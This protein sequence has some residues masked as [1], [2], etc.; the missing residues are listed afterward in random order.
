MRLAAK[1]VL[2]Y[3]VG[4]LLIVAL[5]ATLTIQ[6][7]KQLAMAEHERHAADLAATLQPSIEDALRNGNLADAASYL[8][9]SATRFRHMRVR[10]VEFAGNDAS[11]RPS[12]PAAMIVEQS[13]VTTITMPDKDGRD[14]LY[15]YVPV[16]DESDNEHG[17]IEVAAPHDGTDDL[18]RESL[19]SSLLALV[20]VATLSGMVIVVGGFKMVGKPLNLLIEKVRRA[21]E[22]D[23]SGPVTLRSHDELGKLGSALNQMCDQ[24]ASG[25]EQLRQETA[26]RIET[27]DQLRH[28]ERLNTVG[29]MAAGIA[30]EIGTPLN[31]IT[32]RAELIAGGQ[33]APEDMQASATSIQ[34]E[35]QRIT[36]IIR[37]LLDFARQSTT[38]CTRQDLGALVESTVDLVRPLL[39]KCQAEL[40]LQLPADPLFADVD[41]GQIQQALTN[42]IINAAQSTGDDGQ[43]SVTVSADS[44]P[45]NRAEASSDGEKLYCRIAI[46]DNGRG[47]AADARQHI[48]E[49]FFTTKDV[50]EGTGLGLSISHGIVTEHDGWIDVESEAGVG[51]C[52]SI[53][54]PASDQKGEPA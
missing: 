24:L 21:S 15:T 37:Q 25:Q 38:N 22:G 4:L 44:S 45:V 40:D 18:V 49:P 53:F 29:R 8:N 26:A 32:G 46:R 35:A 13:E 36:K 28:A 2:L 33:L 9:M 6:K 42:L 48:F 11:R 23:F 54:L 20:A 5:F 19:A 1:L 10:W 30:H 34:S 47:I 41:A 50:G 7:D 17:S 51:S 52:F 16:K 14:Y 27:L 31:V 43:V 39:S 3:L 12:V